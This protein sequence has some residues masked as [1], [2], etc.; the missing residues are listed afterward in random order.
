MERKR[1][2]TSLTDDRI[3]ARYPDAETGVDDRVKDKWKMLWE[4]YRYPALVLLLGMLILLIPNHKDASESATMPKD[5]LAQVLSLAQ[6]VGE[7]EVLISE[8][9]VVVVCEGADRAQTKLDILS[10]VASYTGF[11]SDKVTILKLDGKGRG[12]K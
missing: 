8:T 1:K 3:A 12:Q 10:A 2:R 5:A 4:Q 11:G 6:G 9:G 7:A